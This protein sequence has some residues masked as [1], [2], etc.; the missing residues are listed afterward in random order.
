MHIDRLT[1]P[2]RRSLSPAKWKLNSSQPEDLK[3]QRPK[4]FGSASY[5]PF[6]GLVKNW[7]AV[8]KGRLETP[9]VL[10]ARQV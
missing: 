6:F 9:L 8:F 5:R 3:K 10:L 1:G 2:M 7:E 4:D